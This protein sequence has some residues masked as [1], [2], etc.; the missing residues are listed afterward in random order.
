MDHLISSALH[1]KSEAE[2]QSLVI[3]CAIEIHHGPPEPP[4]AKRPKEERPEESDQEGQIG[5]G[6][7]PMEDPLVA[8]LAERVCQKV[9]EMQQR[10]QQRTPQARP[11]AA[12]ASSTLALSKGKQVRPL[13]HMPCLY[14]GR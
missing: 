4:A 1:H 14:G 9:D 12:A 10:G 13:L 5:V 11:S 8:Q 3:D 7:P 2:A 6:E